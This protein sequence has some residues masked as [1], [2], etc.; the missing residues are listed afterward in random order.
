MP[1][2]QEN[3]NL[4]NERIRRAE[5]AAE[6]RE[7]AEPLETIPEV[8]EAEES[9]PVEE[10]EFE[11]PHMDEP[12]H[13]QANVP[14][15]QQMPMGPPGQQPM[16]MGFGQPAPGT[17]TPDYQTM[18]T[19][20][21]QERE[22]R[23]RSEMMRRDL[24]QKAKEEQQVEAKRQQ[25][26]RQRD[27]MLE[28][29]MHR[30]G[31]GAIWA[32]MRKFFSQ[33]I[34]DLVSDTMHGLWTGVK[35]GAGLATDAIVDHYRNRKTENLPLEDYQTAPQMQTENQA[36]QSEPTM[37]AEQPQMQQPE[38]T[39][40]AEQPQMQQPEA[41][42]QAEQPQVQQPEAAAQ[43]ESQV[44]PE[45]AASVEPQAMPQPVADRLSFSDQRDIIGKRL[46]GLDN[47]CRSAGLLLGEQP[48]RRDL[49]VALACMHDP[50]VSGM[51]AGQSRFESEKIMRF[52]S[53][54]QLNPQDGSINQELFRK[55]L[56]AARQPGALERKGFLGALH[57]MSRVITR[58][59]SLDAP[60]RMAAG[61]ALEE[62]GKACAAS[63]KP[64]LKI[65][66]LRNTAIA[67]NINT[68]ET[69]RKITEIRS[70]MT[71]SD[72]YR[73]GKQ[74]QYDEL[75][76]I[77]QMQERG[78]NI[79]NRIMSPEN[80][81]A[82]A[83]SVAL[84][85]NLAEQMVRER[86]ALN[87]QQ[88]V[89]RQANDIAKMPMPNPMSMEVSGFVLHLGRDAKHMETVWQNGLRKLE[90]VKEMQ[91]HSAASILTDMEKNRGDL[92]QRM[93]EDSVK[94][95]S[96]KTYQKEQEKRRVQEKQNENSRGLHA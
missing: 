50:S 20:Q 66:G 48:N 9:D 84:D 70:A 87:R 67:G 63:P 21:Q 79:E 52:L 62:I 82:I 88:E 83:Q 22:N 31:P 23:I 65:V 5:E 49:S 29:R 74:A 8:D 86:I 18:Q 28:Q 71:C 80:A 16:N 76:R 19:A 68:N 37:Q 4:M 14:P 47:M 56:N 44:Q 61:E 35:M 13:R 2:E 59:P 34:G 40:Q 72:I 26:R 96:E 60:H 53:G 54:E 93:R 43:T 33:V 27:Q 55:G 75:D 39:M 36:K 11:Q 30:P 12:P 24:V 85:R 51:S 45:A 73:R 46:N 95:R 25:K 92:A 17:P 1:E 78:M 7:Q 10:Q 41:A 58:A 38:A 6:R 42:A 64:E 77:C 91:T 94:L 15:E 57:D 32:A 90:T 89:S 81:K 3:I 69:I